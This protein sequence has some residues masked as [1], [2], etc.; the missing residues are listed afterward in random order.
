MHTV[1]YVD[2][3]AVTNYYETKF[4]DDNMTLV[5]ASADHFTNLLK[6]VF[7]HSNISACFKGN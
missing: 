4:A 2:L 5:F 1:L 3:F 6:G 7:P